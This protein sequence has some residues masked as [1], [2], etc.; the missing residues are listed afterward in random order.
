MRAV[1]DTNIVVSALI[2]PLGNPGRV[3]DR[4]RQGV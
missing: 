1:V 3:L 4:F 2:Q